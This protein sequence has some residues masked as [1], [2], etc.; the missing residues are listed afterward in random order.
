MALKARPVGGVDEQ[1]D[2]GDAHT[3]K[4]EGHHRFQMQGRAAQRKVEAGKAGETVQ[5]VGAVGQ[6]AKAFVNH[7]GTDNL[8]KAQCGNGKVVTF[9]LQ[10]RQTNEE[11]EQRC[12]KT[13]QD[14]AEHNTQ[15]QAEAAQSLE[16]SSGMEKP[17]P[18]FA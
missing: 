7:G 8:G 15:Q 2:D 13:G 18:P 9:Q 10:H 3:G 6:R 1:Q 12:D 4:E 11:G 17:M 16:S 14:Q 5:K